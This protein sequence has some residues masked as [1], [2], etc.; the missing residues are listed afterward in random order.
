MCIPEVPGEKQIQVFRRAKRIK[1]Y[2]W[3]DSV[4]TEFS[5]ILFWL[6]GEPEKLR[7][8]Q[9]YFH[10]WKVS[11]FSF[12]CWGK[13]TGR[14]EVGPS[15]ILL[16]RQAV[17]FSC[18]GPG[19]PNWSTWLLE[20]FGQITGRHSCFY[21]SSFFG[22]KHKGKE[23]IPDCLRRQGHFTS[24]EVQQFCQ[25]LGRFGGKAWI[26]SLHTELLCGFLHKPGVGGYIEKKGLDSIQV[27]KSLADFNLVE[28]VVRITPHLAR[29]VLYV[30]TH[31]GQG[32]LHYKYLSERRKSLV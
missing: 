14:I 21:F 5:L 20:S 19:I 17:L 30:Q 24:T 29:V 16:P 2:S 22:S 12:V 23:S 10:F 28:K 27:Q 18:Q 3:R 15:T 26:S 25:E 11:L 9:S 6:A 32:A 13:Q 1:L 31:S 8:D 7:K 4:V